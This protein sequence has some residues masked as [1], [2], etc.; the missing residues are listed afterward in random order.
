[1]RTSLTVG[2][3]LARLIICAHR[4]GRGV[5]L[6]GGTG[7]GKTAMLKA[8]AKQHGIGYRRLDAAVLEASDLGGIPTPDA[9]KQGRMTYLRPSWM[10]DPATEPEGMLVIEEATRPNAQVKN[11]LM[12]LISEK[13][14]NGHA[15]PPTW[16]VHGTANPADEDFIDA[17]EMDAAF[18]ARF[19]IV[20]VVANRRDWIGWATTHGVHRDVVAFAEST[21]AIFSMTGMFSRSNPRSWT[22]ISDFLHAVDQ[23]GHE[24]PPTADA[25][26]AFIAGLVG[27]EL[28]QAFITR[29]VEPSACQITAADLVLQYRSAHR[30]LVQRLV[31]ARQVAEVGAI[32]DALMEHLRDPIVFQAAMIDSVQRENIAD[33]VNDLPADIRGLMYKRLPA[34]KKAL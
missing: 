7:L 19:S 15:L 31:S 28:A 23:S 1:M 10:P 33:F 9:I 16:S 2:I 13:E 4:A 5:L 12:N 14:L 17:E 3:A 26:L 34:L 21:P 20:E 18:A 11:G 6:L 22:W 32:A 27:P 25:I 24:G 8:L 30:H 29:R